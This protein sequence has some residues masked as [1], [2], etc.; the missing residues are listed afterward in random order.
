MFP[1]TVNFHF[2][3]L[4]LSFGLAFLGS[5]VAICLIEQLRSSYLHGEKLRWSIRLKW[6]VVIGISFGGVGMWSVDQI[7]LA[8]IQMKI[9]STQHL[10]H[11]KFNLFLSIVSL[12]VC[13]FLVILGILIASYDPMFA[14]TKTE[15]IESFIK[16]TTNLSMTEIKQTKD[17]RMI[18]II[19]TRKPWILIIGGSVGIVIM[20]YLNMKE[21]TFDEELTIHNNIGLLFLSFVI[22]WIGCIGGF[23]ILF[24]LLSIFPSREKLRITSAIILAGTFGIT[25]YISILSISYTIETFDATEIETGNSYNLDYDVILLPAFIGL[26]LF[27]FHALSDSRRL[28]YK[29]RN[30]IQ[31]HGHGITNNRTHTGGETSRTLRNH[32]D[33]NKFLPSSINNKVSSFEHHPSTIR[34]NNNLNTSRQGYSSSQEP[35]SNHFIKPN[36]YSQLQ[37]NN[38]TLRDDHKDPKDPKDHKGVSDDSREDKGDIEDQLIN[39]TSYSIN[40][41]VSPEPNNNQTIS[42]IHPFPSTYSSIDP[43]ETTQSISL[44]NISQ[45]A[46][47]EIT[48]SYH[49]G[50]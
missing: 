8:S 42:H 33:M 5:Y 40:E 13:C 29:Y 25:F 15:I 23:W 7:M 35:C 48:G 27:V 43:E 12:I 38:D 16:Q 17:S 9:T 18:W 41:Q 32:D 50:H 49:F 44:V 26:W 30:Y 3:L 10:I 36:K 11:F 6:L 22:A 37:R 19:A 21:L 4:L 39:I 14:K 47:E 1:I 20:H 45:S 28:I 46:S 31:Q 2:N 24:R 34:H